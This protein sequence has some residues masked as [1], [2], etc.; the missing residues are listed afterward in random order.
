VTDW[1]TVA[2]LGTA[3][4]TLI[5]AVATFASVLSAHRSTRLAERSLL[6]RL[7]P[8]LLPSR[9]EDPP[10]KVPF[11]D[12]RRLRV[13]AGHGLAEVGDQA[14]YLAIALRNVGNG[15]AIL[16]AWKLIPERL[17]GPADQPDVGDFRQLTRDLYIAANNL[18]RSPSI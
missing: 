17:I 7:R 3:G 14:I 18:G 6:V 8:L 10:E 5:L 11:Q 13:P 2:E 1:A 9:L 12:D 4:G 16:V 15:L